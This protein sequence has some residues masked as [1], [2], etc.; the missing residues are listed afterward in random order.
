[1][2]RRT[3]SKG[4]QIR[5]KLH[6]MSQPTVPNATAWPD[7]HEAQRAVLLEVLIHGSRSRAEL[8]RRTGLSRAT[9]MR[10]TRDLVA[11]GLVTEGETPDGSGGRE[12]RR[13]I[14][15]EPA[16]AKGRGRPSEYLRLRPSSA[17]FVGIKLTGDALYAAVT[18]LHSTVVATDER[19]L[20][21]RDV[22]TVV[23][24][25]ATVIGELAGRYRLTAAGVCLAG[26]VKQHR[27]RA[28]VVGS[29]FLGWDE[30]A[31]GELVEGAT[32]LPTAV[33]NDVQALTLA[34]HWF[35][36]GVGSSSL[37][38]IGL[39]AGIGAGL[40]TDDLLIR[41]HRGH[42]GKVGHLFVTDSGPRCDRGHIGCVSAFVTIPAILRNAG[43]ET[44][45]QTLVAAREGD[46]RAGSALR[47]A[48]RALGVVIGTV[49]SLLD[50][51]KVIVT[52]EGLETARF[53]FA[54]VESGIAERLDPASEPVGVELHEFRF[55]EYAW[56]AAI[57]AIRH[58]V[59]PVD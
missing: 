7:L 26:D 16:V 6:V 11:L 22:D 25:I 40:V 13:S 8:A 43:T 53:A 35:G 44:Y 55:A 19:P 1:M 38:V 54:Q 21:A 49:A 42:P 32:G 17:Y 23:G 36:A 20:P 5:D 3:A 2:Y 18:D 41:G 33:S 14:E 47:D 52:G 30:V 37:V 31:V 45:S 4:S 27:G 15:A 59:L 10:L 50:P 51:D 39:G 28:V 29:D 24:L 9:L 12:A 34:H 58:V 57:G 56:A 48:G 46:E